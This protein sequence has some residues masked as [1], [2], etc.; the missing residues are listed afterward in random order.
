LSCLIRERKKSELSDQGKKKE[1]V[2]ELKQSAA[3]LKQ[4]GSQYNDKEL[5]KEADELEVQ[6]DTIEDRGMSPKSRKV[7]RTESF[8]MKNQQLSQ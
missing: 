6:A 3:R 7:L 5:L 4:V 8:Q 2:Q 1:A